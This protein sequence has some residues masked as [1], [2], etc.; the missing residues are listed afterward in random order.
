MVDRSGSQANSVISFGPF[1]LYADERL[2]KKGDETLAVS[3]RALD[4]L[5]ALVDRAGEVVT[6]KELILRVWPD[7]TVEEA[8]LRV[9]INR[10]RKAL[11]EGREDARYV[12]NV[13]GRGYCFVA[14]VTRSPARHIS[15]P[16]ETVAVHPLKNLPA[17]LTRMVGRDG[18]V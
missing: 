8:N 9:Q 15:T 4:I 14:P 16:V 7:A 10:L 6:R 12:V 13:S 11:G 2:L 1:R 17:R 5:I 3:G 18:I